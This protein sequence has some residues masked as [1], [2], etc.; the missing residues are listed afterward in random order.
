MKTL[1]NSVSPRE[2]KFCLK[3]LNLVGFHKLY[4]EMRVVQGEINPKNKIEIINDK[5]KRWDI[6]SRDED[7]LSRLFDRHGTECT[8]VVYGTEDEFFWYQEVFK[9][10]CN[11]VKDPLTWKDDAT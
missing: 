7:S 11:Y 3:R 5:G 1:D 10:Y 9:G 4:Q 2:F 6:N 8:A